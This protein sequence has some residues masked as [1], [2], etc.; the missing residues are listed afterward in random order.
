MQIKDKHE[1]VKRT[2]H[3]PEEKIIGKLK[4]LFASTMIGEINKESELR[5][6]CIADEL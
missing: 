3:W 4:I 6:L 5:R 1:N 2:K